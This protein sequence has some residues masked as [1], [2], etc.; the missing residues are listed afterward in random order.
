MC[1][2]LKLLRLT[3][4]ILLLVSGCNP[5][6]EESKNKKEI[7]HQIDGTT[8]EVLNI[9]GWSNRDIL[10]VYN[11]E[12]MNKLALH[13]LNSGNKT[14]LY[15]TSN[16]IVNAVPRFDGELIAVHE[17]NE[18]S[19]SKVVFIN[20]LGEILFTK[21]YE[22]SELKFNWNNFEDNKVYVQA[23]N[24][25]WTYHTEEILLETGEVRTS[26]INE[27]LF[28][29]ISE[30]EAVYIDWNHTSPSLTGPLKGKN[31]V[32]NK[33][34]TIKDNV[35]AFHVFEN[36]LVTFNLKTDN[37]KK[38]VINGESLKSEKIAFTYEI[39]LPISYSEFI[40]IPIVNYDEKTR[41][42][43]SFETFKNNKHFLVGYVNG[44]KEKLIEAQTAPLM[45]KNE[46]C[47]YG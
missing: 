27:P 23:F 43:Y 37:S 36:T 34:R 24:K 32:E 12:N 30:S 3:V 26:R 17:I 5:K 42:L 4:F 20:A 40:N 18:G 6:A 39:D 46:L 41:T 1:T 13:N 9:F 14:D 2:I 29:W 31:L 33:V 22:S 28:D 38:I 10:F 8:L 21:Q 45:C 11:Q 47:L 19:S 15:E 7:I 25:D 16:I 44:K 35:L